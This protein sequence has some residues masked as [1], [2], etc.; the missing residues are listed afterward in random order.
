MTQ[1]AFSLA[2]QKVKAEPQIPREA[3]RELFRAGVE[4]N[5][6]ETIKDWRGYLLPTIDSSHIALP[7]DVALR[8]YYGTAGRELIVAT[9]CMSILYDIEDDTIVDANIERLTVDARSL[10]K[11]H[12][13][14]LGGM[15]LD[16]GGRS[17]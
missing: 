11:T 15:G 7:P 10:A 8:E 5:C 3:F 1:Q 9:A 2:R 16:F 17:R 6:N 13:E 4:G 14:V 12:I